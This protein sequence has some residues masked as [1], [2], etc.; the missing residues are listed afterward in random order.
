MTRDE[1]A[2]LEDRI[3][4]LENGLAEWRDLAMSNDRQAKAAHATARVAIRHL[5]GVL[6]MAR[7]HAEQ[8]AAD[9]AARDWLVSIGNDAEETK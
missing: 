7:T 1:I 3:D 8:E 4:W 6:N 5:Q 9:T 2:R